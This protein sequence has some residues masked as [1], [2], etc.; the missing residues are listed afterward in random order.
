MYRVLIGN[1][2]G[3]PDSISVPFP[4]REVCL[5]K[6]K[7]LFVRSPSHIAAPTVG[8]TTAIAHTVP[9]ITPTTVSF[10]VLSFTKAS[11]TRA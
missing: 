3:D 10:Q 5:S 6:P 8:P 1:E 2:A 9:F 11:I 4:G 7:Q